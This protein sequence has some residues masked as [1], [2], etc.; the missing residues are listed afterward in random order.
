MQ[1]LAARIAQALLT[2]TT[3]AAAPTQ[4]QAY[5]HRIDI[6][7][8]VQS[9]QRPITLDDIVS[10]R[11]VEEPRISPD[12]GEIAYVV[13]QG[14]RDSN[15][16]RS[17]MYL[18]RMTPGSVPAKLLEEPWLT[19]PR[20][21][22]DGRFVSYLSR[23]SGSTQLWLLDPKSGRTEQMFRHSPSDD[24][25][26]SHSALK[27]SDTLESAVL[28][29]EWSPD[30]RQIAFTTPARESDSAKRKADLRGVVYNDDVM[31]MSTIFYQT[32]SNA[33]TELWTYDVVARRKRKVWVTPGAI[34]QFTW[35]PAGGTLA[36]AYAAPPVQRG[37]SVVFNSDLAIISTTGGS[38]TSIARGEAFEGNPAWSPDGRALA[39]LS[40]MDE[41]STIAVVDLHSGRRIDLGRG[42]IR[43]GHLGL[44][45]S[46]VSDQLFFE[47]G[48]LGD[49]RDGVNGLYAISIASRKHW[50]VS[51]GTDHLS[52][53][54]FNATASV[55]ACIRQTPT[56]PPEPALLDLA[57]RAVRHV[58]NVNPEFANITLGEVAE[59]RWSNKYRAVTNGYLVKPIGFRTGHRYPLLVVLYGFEGAF[60]AA[61]EWITSYPVQAF[62]REGFIVL[63]VNY[64]RAP[65]WRG[66]D[67][68]RGSRAE[69]YG[70]LASIEAGVAIL[71]A[72]GITD[73]QKVGILGWSYGAFLVEFAITQSRIF[74]VASL[75]NGGDY[76]PGAYWLLGRRAFRENYE[77]ILGGPPYGGSLKN[78]V[79]FSPALNA[80]NVRAPVLMEF[81]PHEAILGLEM[82]AALRRSHVPVEF[83]IYPREGHILTEPQHQY[84]SMLRNLQWFQFWLAGRE[85][86]AR[87]M[88]TKAQYVR[89]RAMRD[90]LGVWERN[91]R[92]PGSPAQTE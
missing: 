45:W 88:Y 67:F 90:S 81:N 9:R 18:V 61:A 85:D 71:V 65:G 58:A 26:L 91:A 29:Y 28:A 37:S 23:A 77:R 13:R 62:A 56:V 16:Y 80:Y 82:S 57:S 46:G 34:G 31:S 76:N 92:A 64:P 11:A 50:E 54:T 47:A 83:I 72:Q 36:V 30:G 35:A 75:G 70:P 44:W 48:Q 4:I 12:G 27:P 19:A 10:R 59:M 51:P 39:F 21:S 32:W 74:N 40:L 25:S 69:G 87:D 5:Q 78:W 55:A 68:G 2:V 33:P 89:W 49:D 84:Y 63:M 86:S 53:F 42:L 22:P 7:I 8:V 17:A 6:P 66:R 43:G 52:G 20:W 73:P 24:H 3:G 14:F 60:T 41:K 15:A 1:A 38:L 79:Q